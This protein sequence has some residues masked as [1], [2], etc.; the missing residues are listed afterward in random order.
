M[1]SF[2][3]SLLIRL[4]NKFNFSQKQVANIVEVDQATLGRWEAGESEPKANQLMVLADTFEININDFYKA[5]LAPPR[6][7]NK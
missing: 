7:L 5:N 2:D 4:R 1:K 6:K 3:S